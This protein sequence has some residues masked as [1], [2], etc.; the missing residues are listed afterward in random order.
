METFKPAT[1]TYITMIFETV[2]GNDFKMC[3]I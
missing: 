1:V 2:N 3:I